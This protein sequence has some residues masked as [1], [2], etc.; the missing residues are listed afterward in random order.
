MSRKL[1]I[2]G[3]YNHFKGYKMKV[4]FEAKHSETEEDMVVYIHLDDGRIWVR[5]KDMFLEKITRNG[6]AFYRFELAKEQK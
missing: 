2:G 6:K 5:P 4:L 1:I 3:L